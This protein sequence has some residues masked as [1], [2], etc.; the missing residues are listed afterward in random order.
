M[1]LVLIV[2]FETE[3][4][5][6]FGWNPL[7]MLAKSSVILIRMNPLFGGTKWSLQ[8]L[9]PPWEN[10]GSIYE[11][12]RLHG[13]DPLPDDSLVR[14]KSRFR[15]IAG[16]GMGSWDIAVKG[17]D[18]PARCSDSVLTL[19]SLLHRAD[20]RT[21][22]CPLTVDCGRTAL[23]LSGVVNRGIDRIVAVT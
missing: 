3:Y 14:G 9:T 18:P 21:M 19:R 2:I 1:D 17:A 13:P 7:L 12:V 11:Y 5:I 4:S 8:S 16:H 6:A 20:S 23:T 15:W 22:G 10:L